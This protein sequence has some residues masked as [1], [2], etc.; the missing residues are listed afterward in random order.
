MLALLASRGFDAEVV[1][2]GGGPLERE[3]ERIGVAVRTMEFGKFSALENPFWLIGFVR[4]FNEILQKSRPDAVVINL[5]GNSPLVSMSAWWTEVPIIRYCRFEFRPPERWIDRWSWKLARAIICPSRHV[6]EQVRAAFPAQ[7]HHQ[8]FHIFD[9]HHHQL[10]K[11][12]QVS[13][14]RKRWGIET[15][16]VLGCVARLHHAK[17]IEIAVYATA[18]LRQ[19]VDNVRLLIVGGHDGSEA[20]KH[21][22]MELQQL[23]ADLGVGDAVVFTGYLPADEM[24][25]AMATLDA[26][27]LPSESES[28]GLSL[29]ESWA[30][31][32][33]TVASDVGGCREIT[34]ASGAGF[35]AP[36]GNIDAFAQHLQTLLLMP[37][38]AQEL[39]ERGRAWV[40][41]NCSPEKY[42]ARF[43]E[44][45]SIAITRPS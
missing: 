44:I 22:Q 23:A 9:S 43:E 24:P 17:R 32:R 36:P 19:E 20:G 42:A 13:A 26:C 3:L 31:G 16:K 38:L 28:L 1:C 34:Q 18:R 25:A 4:E 30:Q 27:V 7:K 8:I 14:F 10:A 5:D 21:Y 11:R 2:T 29:I 12:S 39:G 15:H 6:A 40:L 37:D 45:A 33:P 35:L 41:E